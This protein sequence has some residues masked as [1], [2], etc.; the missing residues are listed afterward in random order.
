MSDDSKNVSELAACII[1]ESAPVAKRIQCAF[2]LRNNVGGE[3]AIDALQ[4]G[5]KSPSVLLAH[6]IAYLLGQ[7]GDEY[8]I[9][10]LTS[11]LENMSLDPIVRHEAAE[12]LAAI[13]AEESY[14]VLV[15]FCDDPHIEVSDTCKISVER[16]EWRKVNPEL[17]AAEKTASH[18]HSVDPAPGH[19][20]ETAEK[21]IPELQDILLNEKLS[22]FKRYQA[23]FKLR[24]LGDEE[25][26]KALCTGFKDRSAVF[27]HEVAYVLGQLQHPAAVEALTEVLKDL[28]EHAMVRHEAAEALGA[29][30]HDSCQPLLEAFQKDQDKIVS[31]SCDVAL[32]TAQYWDEFDNA[33]TE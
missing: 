12:A 30:T 11:T 28:K 19:A 29:I 2:L 17:S 21:S 6:E 26:I 4:P 13:G 5:L 24:N 32:S 9:P 23:M 33:S 3:K 8:A 25:A 10:G 20:E 15:K 31:E 14:P 7:M 18:F 16:I 1:D 27:R 22:L